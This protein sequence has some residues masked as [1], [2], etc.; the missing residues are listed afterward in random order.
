MESLVY[1]AL[2][3]TVEKKETEGKLESLDR[4]VQM[5]LKALR[6]PQEI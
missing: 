2:K 3:E 1:P 4:L 6:V 5:V